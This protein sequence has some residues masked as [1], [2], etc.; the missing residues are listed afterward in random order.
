MYQIKNSVLIINQLSLHMH[1]FVASDIIIDQTELAMSDNNSI[2]ILFMTDARQLQTG[3]D[4]ARSICTC[5]AING[6]HQVHM[7]VDVV[8]H[9]TPLLL[10]QLQ[11][12]M[13]QQ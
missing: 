10:I 11:S 9:H 6:A 13:Q 5:L 1:L 12:C 2:I 4:P 3:D 8:S 7:T